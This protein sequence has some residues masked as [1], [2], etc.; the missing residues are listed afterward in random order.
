M[1]NTNNRKARFVSQTGAYIKSNEYYFGR[2][3][4]MGHISKKALSSLDLAKGTYPKFFHSIFIP[5]G[6]DKTLAEMDVYEFSKY[7][8]I[9]KSIKE[10]INQLDYSYLFHD[11]YT[12]FEL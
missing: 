8:Y 3:E 7:D 11:S 5:D 6:S 1:G 9:R 4:T 2:G 12:L 10:L